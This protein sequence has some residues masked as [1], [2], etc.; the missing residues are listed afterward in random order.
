VRITAD[1]NL[2]VRAIVEDDPE[3]AALA[4][5]LLSR[6]S[7]IGIPV[8]VF[9]ELVWVLKRGYRRSTPKVVAA[10]AALLEVETVATDRLTVEA[11][12]AV[13]RAGG[14][15]ADGVIAYEGAGLGGSLFATF[16]RAAVEQLRQAGMSAADPAELVS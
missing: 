11:G 4:K 14:D 1:T 3:Q 16:D 10:I 5:A 2:L 7:M 12:L 13:L 9:C 6:A 15:F 8:P